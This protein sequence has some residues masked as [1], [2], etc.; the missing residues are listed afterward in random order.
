MDFID[1]AAKRFSA[2]KYTAEKVEPEKLQKILEAGRLAPSACNN[3][4][5]KL[6]V[7]ESDEGLRKLGKASNTFGAP[8]AIIVCSDLDRCWKR[9]YDRKSSGDIDAS[10]V[11]DHLMLQTTEL[12]LGSVWVCSFN[13]EILRKEFNIPGNFEPVNILII[14]YSADETPNPRHFIRKDLNE[15]VIRESF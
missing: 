11:T 1:L 15:T 9:P 5:V 12:G 7:V 13:P 3:Q 2:R 4:P 8:L 14:G 10:I 6:I